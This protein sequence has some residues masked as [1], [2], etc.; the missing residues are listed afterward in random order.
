MAKKQA[1]RKNL[2]ALK[3]LNGLKKQCAKRVQ[4]VSLCLCAFVPSREKTM[5]KAKKN[6]FN[7]SNQWH[8]KNQAKR[9][10]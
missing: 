9:K 7:P 8:I 6:P 4:F 2:N 1:K 5:S 10:T 3:Y